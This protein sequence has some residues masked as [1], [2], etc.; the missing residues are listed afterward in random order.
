MRYDGTPPTTTAGRSEDD[1]AA[2]RRC[3]VG[4]LFAAALDG[5]PL[6]GEELADLAPWDSTAA[7]AF[8]ALAVAEFVRDQGGIE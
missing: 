3:Y 5:D 1:T 4:R 6:A 2:P 7:A 8:E